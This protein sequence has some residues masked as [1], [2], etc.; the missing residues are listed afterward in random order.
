MEVAS[1]TDDTLEP[2][3]LTLQEPGYEDLHAAAAIHPITSAGRGA[4]PHR[5]DAAGPV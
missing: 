5:S 2:D 3:G 4:V 1:D